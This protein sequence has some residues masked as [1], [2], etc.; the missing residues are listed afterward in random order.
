MHCPFCDADKESLK[1]IDSRT[2]EGGRAI[3]RRRQCLKC[4]KRFTTYERIEERVR[5][6]V[7]KKDGRRMPWDRAKIISGLERALFKRPVPESELLRI[8]DEV[9][10]E[11][12]KSCDREVHSTMVGA[13]VTDKL[14]RV[15]QVAYVRFASV[16]REFKTLEE[17]V[18][19]AKAVI[20]ARRYEDPGQGRLFI[21]PPGQQ[22]QRNGNEAGEPEH[23][24]RRK[25][26]RSNG[27]AEK[28]HEAPAE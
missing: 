19:E 15:D 4:D 9:E 2:C 27:K 7:M 5:L 8:V 18:D 25:S 3:R 20:D 22:A 17:L 24:P 21:E 26:K 12:F 28:A 6:V 23:A 14:R 1:V 16:Y 10:D 13:L 11:I